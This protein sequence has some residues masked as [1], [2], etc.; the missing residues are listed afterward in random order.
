MTAEH[1]DSSLQYVCAECGSGLDTSVII[2]VEGVPKSICMSR[3]CQAE[4][5]GGRG[6]VV[7]VESA[8]VKF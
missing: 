2:T 8:G 7:D 4:A 5:K 3:R 1:G 6:R